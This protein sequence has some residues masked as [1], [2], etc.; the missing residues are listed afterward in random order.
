MRV[1]WQD[2]RAACRK[3][4]S[5]EDC[6]TLPMAWR[7][8]DDDLSGWL[9]LREFDPDAFEKL[10]QFTLWTHESFGSTLA[11]FP[12]LLGNKD[13]KLTLTEFR[14]A[15]KP[16]GLGDDIVHYIFSGLDVDS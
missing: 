12:K 16:S 13:G 3:V 15:C 7:A 14:Q 10:M 4:L 1:A 5:A 9:S 2:F 6:R 11:A 8:L